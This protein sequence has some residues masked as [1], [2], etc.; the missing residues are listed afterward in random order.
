MQNCGFICR[1][2]CKKRDV[3]SLL[4]SFMLI[5]AATGIG[6]APLKLAPEW[7][8]QGLRAPESVLVYADGKQKYL[9]ASEMEGE[10]TAVDGKGGIAK[11]SLDGEIIDADWVRGL[12]A[13]KGMA[14]FKGKLYVADIH[15]VVVIDIASH[16]IETKI[17]VPDAVFLND[18]AADQNGV[19]YVSDTRTNKVHRITDGEPEV[20]ISP[21]AT[22]NGLRPI[23]SNLA[24][25]AGT[26]LWVADPKG[27]HYMLAKGFADKID[28]IE[29]TRL[30]EFVVSC[31][32]GLLYYVHADGTLE[33][34]L[35]SRADHKNTADIGYDKESQTVFVPN[36][37]DGITA[38]KLQ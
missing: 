21:I 8:A 30:G 35:D 17:P 12:N 26:E 34:L 6:A 16:K 37:K 11:L 28:G 14:A 3:M 15:E 36:F 1:Y 2:L 29:M 18:V 20:F 5:F 33:L 32:V 23:G 4:A 24:I 38:Y 27:Q 7:V 31:W 9:F 22:P 10:S 25:G 13:P 19:V